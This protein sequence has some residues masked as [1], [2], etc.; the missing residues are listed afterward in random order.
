MAE[1]V[2]RCGIDVICSEMVV[3]CKTTLKGQLSNTGY[4]NTKAVMEKQA[5]QIGDVNF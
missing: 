2:A 5:N 3:M 4:R 1:I